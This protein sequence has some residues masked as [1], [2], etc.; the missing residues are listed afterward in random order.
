MPRSI[1][2]LIPYTVAMH[3]NGIKIRWDDPVFDEYDRSN[4]V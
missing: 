2:D 1:N 4:N 3:Q